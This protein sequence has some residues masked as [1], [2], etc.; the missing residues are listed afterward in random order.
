M[1][2][3]MVERR[4]VREPGNQCLVFRVEGF[5]FNMEN[6]MVGRRALSVWCLVFGL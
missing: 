1:E 6:V 2:N 3:V 5:T 4:A